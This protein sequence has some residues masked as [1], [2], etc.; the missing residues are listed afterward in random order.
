MAFAD[1]D[2]HLIQHLA[3]QRG[4]GVVAHDDDLDSA[5]D[6]PHR[7]LVL[8]APAQFAVSPQ[9]LYGFFLAI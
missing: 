1:G 6:N 4:L 3:D 5:V 2:Q 8:D 9:K 7:R